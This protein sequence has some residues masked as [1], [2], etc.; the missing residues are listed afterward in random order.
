MLEEPDLV[1]E[2]TQ[3]LRESILAVLADSLNDFEGVKG[4]WIV[5]LG[6]LHVCKVFLPHPL[7]VLDD[8]GQ[9]DGHGDEASVH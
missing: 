5:G 2:P 8:L 9:Q 4:Q 7:L 1:K 3:S 6:Q